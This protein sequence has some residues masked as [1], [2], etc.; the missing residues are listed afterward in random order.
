M[1]TS[2]IPL[3]CLFS[4]YH[5]LVLSD[6]LTNVTSLTQEFL[7]LNAT[8]AF[9]VATSEEEFLSFLSYQSFSSCCNW[10]T[11]VSPNLLFVS[12]LQSRSMEM[13]TD[14]FGS[15]G[16][17]AVI[18]VPLQMSLFP[19][20]REAVITQTVSSACS[21]PGLCDTG[22]SHQAVRPWMNYCLHK[23]WICGVH[24]STH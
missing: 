18:V 10:A 15:R 23:R 20:R 22:R 24:R 16:E 1:I 4:R 7:Y 2:L 12:V 6:D 9:G 3:P 5:L 13:C 19:N 11:K 21:S 8:W 14:W 17:C